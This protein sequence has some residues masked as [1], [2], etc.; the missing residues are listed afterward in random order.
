MGGPV[1]EETFTHSHPSWSSNILYQISFI[2]H[3][4]RSITFLV[5]LKRENTKEVRKEY[6]KSR[7][8]AIYVI[9]KTVTAANIHAK[10]TFHF[11]HAIL[12]ATSAHSLPSQSYICNEC[13]SAQTRSWMNG[14]AR[15]WL[16]ERRLLGSN[17]SIFSR[18]SLSC[19]TLRSWSSGSRCEPTMSAIRSLLGLMVLITD[20]F[21]YKHKP[22][23]FTVNLC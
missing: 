17:M 5:V 9:T 13:P 23:C 11:S 21:S 7:Q 15:A 14:C 22:T 19:E 12:Y 6:K 4:L 8:N 1:P 10:Y 18:K 3:L 20:T 16:M 2:D